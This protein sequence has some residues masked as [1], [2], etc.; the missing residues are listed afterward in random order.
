MEQQKMQKQNELT[1]EDTQMIQ[2]EVSEAKKTITKQADQVLAQIE[3]NKGKALAQ[4]DTQKV[5]ANVQKLTQEIEQVYNFERDVAIAK[6]QDPKFDES[7]GKIKSY[8]T[9]YR[10]TFKDSDNNLRDPAKNEMERAERWKDDKAKRE[11][12]AVKQALDAQKTQF[13]IAQSAA[14]ANAAGA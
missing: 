2:T 1:Q 14:V 6:L 13:E 7:V 3:S 12:E 9:S 11:F 8:M 4:A 10:R 5:D